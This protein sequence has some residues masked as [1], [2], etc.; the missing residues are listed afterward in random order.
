SR[1]DASG[2]GGDRI[3]LVE[4][5][6]G[7][8]ERTVVV[9]EEDESGRVAAVSAAHAAASIACNE[10]RQRVGMD[11][12]RAC[13]VEDRDPVRPAAG[14]AVPRASTRDRPVSPDPA[15]AVPEIVTTGIG[16][17]R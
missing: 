13:D 3:E 16:G 12:R 7:L 4:T 11:R 1:A 14:P 17:A 9:S 8:V 6:L 5:G 15:P 10:S 2:P